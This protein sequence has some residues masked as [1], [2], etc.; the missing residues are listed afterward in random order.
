MGEYS[1]STRA[2]S[3]IL[4]WKGRVE[5]YGGVGRDCVSVL[6]DMNSSRFGVAMGR[7][8]G[9]DLSVLKEEKY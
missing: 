9:D 4:P 3:D 1:F 5:W 8:D 7:T 2:L 6:L